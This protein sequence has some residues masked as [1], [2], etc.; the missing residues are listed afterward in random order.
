MN[1]VEEPTEQN[2][3]EN[4][5]EHQQ[6]NQECLLRLLSQISSELMDSVHL[7]LL[8]EESYHT[9]KEKKTSGNRFFS[10]VILLDVVALAK[11]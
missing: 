5:K 7:H 8:Q 10:N 3:E 4:H 2:L 9:E 6:E 11:S 1:Q